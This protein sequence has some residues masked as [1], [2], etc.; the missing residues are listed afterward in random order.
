MVI[1]LLITLLGTIAIVAL[2]IDQYPDLVPPMVTVKVSYPGASAQTI[3]KTVLTPLEIQLN[4][5]EDMLYIASTASS[6]AGA[7]S[8]D[9]PYDFFRP[10]ERFT[11]ML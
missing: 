9:R 5:M 1:S 4:G 8:I 3:A 10:Y 11:I 7:G 6:G 2:P